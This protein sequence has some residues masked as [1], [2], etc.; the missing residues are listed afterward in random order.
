MNSTAVTSPRLASSGR[1][2]AALAWTV[3][4]SV[5]ALMA[6]LRLVVLHDWLLPVAYGVPLVLNLWLRR[7]DTLWTMALSFMAIAGIKNA[8]I[9]GPIAFGSRQDQLAAVGLIW[10]DTLVIAAVL[11][12][13]I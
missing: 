8:V 7:R 5:V 9:L 12:A 1:P 10:F 6:A 11:H 3:C 13:F 2:S 4:L